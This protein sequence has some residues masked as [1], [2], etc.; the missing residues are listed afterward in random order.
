MTAKRTPTNPATTDDVD[1]RTALGRRACLA[2]LAPGGHG[3]VA[4]STRA[5][6]ISVPVQF[7]MVGE[8][9][10]FTL[11]VDEAISRAVAGSVVAFGTGHA[12][13]GVRPAWDVHVTGVAS[14]LGGPSP[15]PGFRLSSAVVSGW[16]A[17]D[18]RPS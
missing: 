15:R 6:P 17:N 18:D 3:R 11:G 16:Q 2:L 1:T 14:S 5:L 9:V 10:V 12:G 7:E 8:D 4:A 13:G